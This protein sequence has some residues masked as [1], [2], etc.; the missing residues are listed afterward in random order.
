MTLV[1][2]YA[3]LG[4][5][6]TYIGISDTFADT[7]LEWSLSA[8]SRAI[9]GYCGRRFWLDTNPSARWFRPATMQLC[10]VDDIGA[11]DGVVV[12]VDGDDDGTAET[13]WQS[14]DYRMEPLNHTQGGLEGWPWTRIRA[15]WTGHVFPYWTWRNPFSVS[16]TARWGWATIPDPVH[17]ATLLVASDI[18]KRKDTPF[19]IA[20][21]YSDLGA[22]RIGGNVFTQAT[23]LLFPYQRGTA[24]HAVSAGVA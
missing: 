24:V 6:K 11:P 23:V 14:V 7:K 1:N 13:T 18:Y 10:E 17:Q 4:D 16:V 22:L 19:G 21:G 8:A 12:A 15:T 2:C 9:D 5:L 3:D 20:G